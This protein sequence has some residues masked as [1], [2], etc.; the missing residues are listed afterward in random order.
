MIINP[1]Q[2]ALVNKNLG[3]LRAGLTPW[4]GQIGVNKGF[5]VFDTWAHGLRALVKLLRTYHRR[6]W[7]VNPET[8]VKHYAPGSDGNNEK[9]YA[10]FV[11]PAWSQSD[12]D[13][14]RIYHVLAYYIVWQETGNNLDI[15]SLN[16]TGDRNKFLHYIIQS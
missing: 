9:A 8:F 15:L 13:H 1:L 7:L 2:L 6:G 10:Q 12:D 3:N 11:A 16:I 5:C 4:L 14:N